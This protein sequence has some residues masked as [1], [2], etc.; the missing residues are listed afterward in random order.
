MCSCIHIRIW[1]L[2]YFLC[3]YAGGNVRVCVCVF[4]CYLLVEYRGVRQD[5]IQAERLLIAYSVQSG[6]LC[7]RQRVQLRLIYYISQR[8]RIYVLK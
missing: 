3:C 4:V 2:V 1:L 7:K 5:F 8:C 6:C